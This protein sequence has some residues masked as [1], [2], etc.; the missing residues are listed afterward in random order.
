MATMHVGQDF[1]AEALEKFVK[2]NAV[3]MVTIFDSDPS[4]HEYVAKFFELPTDKVHIIGFSHF[5]NEEKKSL[6]HFLFQ[7][8]MSSG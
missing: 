7:L 4:L 2:E 6:F 3:P 8:T 5:R 1:K